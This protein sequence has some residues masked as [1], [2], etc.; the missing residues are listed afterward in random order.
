MSTFPYMFYSFI[1]WYVLINLF[2][3]LKEINIH[4]A[5]IFWT[6]IPFICI[7]IES[8]EFYI[9]QRDVKFRIQINRG[10]LLTKPVKIK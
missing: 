9:R 1:Y 5:Y 4:E 7:N 10:V 2:Y 8:I 6:F 3:V